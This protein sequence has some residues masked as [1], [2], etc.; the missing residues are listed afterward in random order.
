MASEV[1][2]TFCT[3]FLYKFSIGMNDI[4]VYCIFIRIELTVKDMP[5]VCLCHGNE[6][7]A[8]KSSLT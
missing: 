4:V 5:H 7:S 8:R 6:A 3:V 1:M 2:E